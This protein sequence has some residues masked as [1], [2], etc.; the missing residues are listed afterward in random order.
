VLVADGAPPG[1][2]GKFFYGPAQVQLPFGNGLLCAGPG[3]IGIFRLTPP[4]PA[5]PDGNAVRPL[6]FTAPPASTGPGAIT[7]GSTWNFQYWY[8]DPNVGAGFNLSD[9]LSATFCP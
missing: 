8:R 9:A 5:N 7:P 3:A 1:K 6:D 4:Q 2:L